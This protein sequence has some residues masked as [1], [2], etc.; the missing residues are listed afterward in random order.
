MLSFKRLWTFY[1]EAQFSTLSLLGDQ[2]HKTSSSSSPE[3]TQSHRI[4]LEGT[5]GL[6]EDQK[7]EHT[8]NDSPSSGGQ[9]SRDHEGELT[10][11]DVLVSYT[12]LSKQ[13]ELTLSSAILAVS[14]ASVQEASISIAGIVNTLVNIANAR[15]RPVV[16]T[17]PEQEQRRAI[18]IVQPTID[19]KDKGKG[20][21]AM[22]A[23][24][25]PIGSE[26]DER[27]IR[28]INKKAERE[29]SD[30]GVDNTEKRK[31]GSRMKRMC[32]RKK[33]DADLE[34]EEQ[35]RVFLNIIPD[36]KGEVDYAVLD[37]RV[38]RADGS[39]R[40]IK[41]FT[42]M[43]SKFDRLDFIELHSLVMQ[44]FEITTPEEEWILKSWNF[45]ENYRVHILML[46]DGT[47][48]YMPAERRYPL[49]KETLERMMA[50]RLI[51]ESKSEAVF[52]L[53]RFIQKQID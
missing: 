6:G 8:P 11:R 2:T 37:K 15:P 50:L 4:V 10:L 17:D 12:K 29:S 7:M 45:Y 13:K 31:A 35:L 24:F 34:E 26:E 47:E 33:T 44:R 39:S 38:F 1:H 46:E 48:F 22:I 18:P 28:D 9:T 16:I 21:M 27:R 51:A 30:K 23:N 20:K 32:K 41:N 3:N 43:V 5:G 49:I 25:V 42:E 40:Y 14:T 53:L 36:E 19:P 52:Y